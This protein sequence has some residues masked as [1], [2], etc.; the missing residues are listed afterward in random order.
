MNTAQQ[1][2]SKADEA[3]AIADSH[4]QTEA[5]SIIESALQK[6]EAGEYQ[7]YIYKSIHPKIKVILQNNGF[8]VDETSARNESTTTIA[9]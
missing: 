5:N 9:W 1:L 3:R 4:F 8:R 7:M 2:R 6:A